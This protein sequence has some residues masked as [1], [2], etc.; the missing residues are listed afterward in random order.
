MALIWVWNSST[1]GSLGMQD[2]G[3]RDREF[4]PVPPSC[5]LFFLRGLTRSLSVRR[6]FTCAAEFGESGFNLGVQ[7]VQ[8]RDQFIV[9][10]VETIDQFARRKRRIEHRAWPEAGTEITG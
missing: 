5:I 7:L 4:I 10:G 3:G 9:P 1:K 8:A 6:R 2:A